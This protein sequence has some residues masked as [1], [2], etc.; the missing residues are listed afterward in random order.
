MKFRWFFLWLAMTTCLAL[1]YVQQR[2]VLV[3]EGYRVEALRRTKEELLDQHRVLHYNVLTLQS[4]IILSKRLEDGDVQLNPPQHVEI[5][6]RQMVPYPTSLQRVEAGAV[7]PTWVQ[8]ARRLAVG[9][10]GVDRQ[11]EAKPDQGD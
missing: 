8:Q 7:K 6:H 5:L 3:T 9:V 4:P 10:L 1:V 11:A 2:V